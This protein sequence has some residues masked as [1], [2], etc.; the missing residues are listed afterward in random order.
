MRR[1]VTH[2]V[3]TL[4][5]VVALASCLLINPASAVLQTADELL[6]PADVLEDLSLVLDEPPPDTAAPVGAE[7]RAEADAHRA[8]ESRVVSTAAQRWTGARDRSVDNVVRVFDS[9]RAAK[10][11][12]RPYLDTDVSEECVESRLERGATIPGTD[13]H[14]DDREGINVGKAPKAGFLAEGSYAIEDGERQL[15]NETILVRLGPAV[16]ETSFTAR[17]EGFPEFARRLE[18]IV[19]EAGQQARS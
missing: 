5:A 8:T 4:S 13:W 10:T 14:A 17:R 6:L 16:V 12:L 7:C 18:R 19:R 11:F 9:V 2:R 1:R 15:L 3:A